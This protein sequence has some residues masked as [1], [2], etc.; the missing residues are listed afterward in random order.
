MHFID[1]EYSG[2]N[3][4]PFDIASHFCE[5]NKTIV[6]NGE[7]KRI[8]YYPT[9]EFQKLW[10]KTY[11]EWCKK[12]QK[13]TNLEVSKTEIEDTYDLVCKSALV[14]DIFIGLWAVIQVKYSDINYDFKRSAVSRFSEFKRKKLLYLK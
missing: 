5:F 7:S 2:L 4:G 13:S 11:L 9:E 6:G 3:W 12:F 14:A 1:Y 8:K 10:I